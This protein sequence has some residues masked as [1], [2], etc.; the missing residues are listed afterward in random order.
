VNDLSEDAVASIHRNVTFN[1]LDPA[2]VIPNH[3]DAVSLM[4]ENRSASRN[5]DVVDLDPY[6]RWDRGCDRRCFA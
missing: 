1:G 6:V 5:F 2:R 4:M 3:G